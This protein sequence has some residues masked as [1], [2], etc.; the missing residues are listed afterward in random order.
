MSSEMSQSVITVIENFGWPVVTVLLA[1]LLAVFLGRKKIC[2]AWVSARSMRGLARLGYKQ[3]SNIQFEDGLGGT[4]NI[5]RLVMRC[6][7]ISL[8]LCMRYPGSIFCAENID[9]WTQMFNGKSYR[10]SNPLVDLDY[11][12][13]AISVLVPEIHVDG[14]LFFGHDAEFPKGKPERVFGLDGVP[15]ELQRDKK[16]AVDDKVE[17]AWL[18]LCDSYGR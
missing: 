1:L 16:V 7:G 18:I 8:I 14:Y 9:E 10:F 13:K 5:D 17:K 11:Q 15:I 2:D 4:L 3:M 12:V 6:D